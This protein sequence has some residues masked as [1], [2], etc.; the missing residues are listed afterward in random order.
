[1]KINAATLFLFKEL[2]YKMVK[3][4][5]KLCFLFSYHLQVIKTGRCDK[6]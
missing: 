4:K 2:G 5:E 1:M 3:I 6:F